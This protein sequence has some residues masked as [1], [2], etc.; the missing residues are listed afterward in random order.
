MDLCQR[1]NLRRPLF[2]AFMR[3]M[4]AYSSS[5]PTSGAGPLMGIS[6][7]QGIS[8]GLQVRGAR[9]LSV[10]M[11]TDRMKRYYQGNVLQCC[12]TCA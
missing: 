7:I 4:A 11:I 2:P 8:P 1:F 12:E 6:L 9:S 10:Y 5:S 3:F